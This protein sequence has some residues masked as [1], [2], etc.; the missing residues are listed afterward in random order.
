MSLRKKWNKF[1]RYIYG[2]VGLT[3]I[4]SLIWA[5]LKMVEGTFF[6]TMGFF[7]SL[8][9]FI[10]VIGGINWIPK[11]FGGKDLFLN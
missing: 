11:A 2:V 10:L 6:N 8:A 1:G 5:I 3:A 4:G 9:Y 7:G